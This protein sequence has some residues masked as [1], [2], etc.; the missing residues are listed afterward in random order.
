MVLPETVSKRHRIFCRRFDECP[1]AARD[2]CGCAQTMLAPLILTAFVATVS[3]CFASE[4]N[5]GL[6]AIG[7]IDAARSEILVNPYAFTLGSGI[8]VALIG[9]HERGLDPRGGGS[10]HRQAAPGSSPNL[11]LPRCFSSSI[12]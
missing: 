6:L 9:A 12:S 7:A 4:Q 5:C 2:G 11:G 3:T 1:D 8:P 10:P